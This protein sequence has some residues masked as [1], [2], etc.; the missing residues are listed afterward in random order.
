MSELTQSPTPLPPVRTFYTIEVVHGQS[1]ELNDLALAIVRLG[2]ETV[3]A[4]A[5]T[6]LLD[7]KH[8]PQVSLRYE[9]T[10]QA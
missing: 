10:V 1:E 2:V 5:R 6:R 9:G 3:I 4:E 8:A 7:R